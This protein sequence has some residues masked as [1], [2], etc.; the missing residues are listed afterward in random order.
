MLGEF[1]TGAT[2]ERG[3]QIWIGLYFLYFGLNGV[4]HW[5]KVP[6]QSMDFENFI[7]A[8]Q[9]T[10]YLMIVVKCLEIGSGFLLVLGWV[11]LLATLL[12]APIV[13]VIV[14]AHLFLNL[15]RGWKMALLT[16]A[17][18]IALVLCQWDQWSLLWTS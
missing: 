1:L 2:L 10:G 15:W 8:L 5:Q 7:Q 16:G 17:P 9:A 6:A 13:F 18:F 12:L 14:T 4:F 3:L 11:P